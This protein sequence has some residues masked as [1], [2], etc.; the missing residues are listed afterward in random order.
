M[1]E[2]LPLADLFIGGREDAEAV[3][4]LSGEASVEKLARGITAEF[5]RLQR[6]APGDTAQ[7]RSM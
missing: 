7:P 5:P 6:V 4:G 1:R 2:L 3:L